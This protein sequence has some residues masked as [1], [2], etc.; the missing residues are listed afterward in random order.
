M[1]GEL[2]FDCSV[3]RDLLTRVELDNE[4]LANNV[5]YGLAGFI[6]TYIGMLSGL[7]RL[8]L[9]RNRGLTS[10]LT[11]SL[12]STFCS[13]VNLTHLDLSHNSIRGE[14]PLCNATAIAFA[15]LEE[16][17]LNGN[18]FKGTLPPW[19]S[20]SGLTSVNVSRNLFFGSTFGVPRGLP[21]C[22]LSVVGDSNCFEDCQQS[23]TCT[24]GKRDVCNVC[25]GDNKSCLD[26]GGIPFGTSTYD[27]CD[28]CGGDSQSCRDCAGTPNGIRQYDVCNIC[29][30]NGT[31]C[32][33]CMNVP[34]GTNLYDA[35]GVCGGDGFCTPPSRGAID[36]TTSSATTTTSSATVTTNPAPEQLPPGAIAGIAAAVVG[37]FFVVA[38]TLAVVWF[39]KTVGRTSTD[40]TLATIH[41]ALESARSSDDSDSPTQPQVR[42]PDREPEPAASLNEERPQHFVVATR[43]QPTLSRSSRQGNAP[44]DGPCNCAPAMSA[45]GDRIKSIATIRHS[46]QPI[47]YGTL[48][49]IVSPTEC[50]LLTAWHV[51]FDR[52]RNSDNLE[53][54]LRAN[55]TAT[56]DSA[57]ATSARAF[58]LATVV[59]YSRQ[60]NTD[61]DGTVDWVV[62]SLT[63]AGNQLR[64]APSDTLIGLA[65]DLAHDNS[66]FDFCQAQGKPSP[67][68]TVR[69]TLPNGHA[70]EYSAGSSREK[71]R[72]L[73]PK[74][75]E[76]GING[77][78]GAPLLTV[79]NLLV[80]VYTGDDERGGRGWL[81][82]FTGQGRADLS[83]VVAED[84]RL[85]AVYRSQ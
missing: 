81:F 29:G 52:A 54:R 57:P 22:A 17:R 38:A 80:G 47:G 82:R 19:F 20:S 53:P 64:Y 4:M 30:G 15:N 13:L 12:P 45:V 24:T 28:V 6:S 9:G 77:M 40:V 65:W 46:G 21:S 68:C 72:T 85:C 18:F 78:S 34:Y 35:C 76:R 59:D 71:W 3:N 55:L 79:D 56:F 69:L 49:C 39:R 36:A 37:A 43:E 25:N 48:L 51:A 74:S 73:V 2:I 83:Q 31:T 14:L 5:P 11:G 42:S 8:N 26:C 58:R 62:L 32:R 60:S 44:P 61:G 70:F 33:D 84:E 1:A 75:H 50:H 10:G 63:V 41:N 27:R 67:L 23:C 7:T 66:F 16:L